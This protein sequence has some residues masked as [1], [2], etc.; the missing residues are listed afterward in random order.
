MEDKQLDFNQPFLSV[1]RTSITVSSGGRENVRKNNDE[2]VPKLPPLPA[3]K[4]ELKTDPVRDPG[5]VPFVW[6]QTP[7]RPKPQMHDPKRS[8]GSG[9]PK[10]PPVRALNLDKGSQASSTTRI[11]ASVGRNT[12]KEIK[13]EETGSCTSDE[14]D[15]SY[16]DA[17]GTLSRTESLFYNCN[18]S[19]ITGLD[20]PDLKP[21]WSF[22]TD[23]Q[24]RDFMMDRFLPAAKAVA[25]ETSLYSNRK[26]PV[27]R[28]QPRL[29]KEALF[30][31]RRCTTDQNMLISVPCYS[32]G[33]EVED[34]EDDDDDYDGP[35]NPSTGVCGL[36]PRLCLQSSF[37]LLNPVTG[38]RKPVQ[39][40]NSSVCKTKV[41]SSN[42]ASC[43]K[44]ENKNHT[45]P[46]YEPRST[47]RLQPTGLY[48]GKDEL[49]SVSNQI[50]H[51]RDLREVDGSHQCKS[52]QNKCASPFPMDFSQSA[53][54]EEKRLLGIAK[55]FKNSGVIRSCSPPNNVRNLQ[56]LFANEMNELES[57]CLSPVVEKILYVDS[58]HAVKP[59][60]SNSVSSDMK[61][62][63]SYKKVVADTLTKPSEIEEKDSR[64]SV[65]DFKYLEAVDGRTKVLS[66]SLESV[67]SGFFSLSDRHFHDGKM[68]KMDSYGPI[69]TLEQ[70]LL[71]S[72]SPKVDRSVKIDMKSQFDIDA[73]GNL[74]GLI[75]DS[76]LLTRDK[77]ADDGQLSTELSKQESQMHCLPPVPLPPPLPNSPSESWLMR[78]L[79]AISS[80]NFSSTS[81]LVMHASPKVQAFKKD[82]GG[83]K[84]EHI[85][86][87]SN[88]HG[89]SRFPEEV[90]API[91]EA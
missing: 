65:K 31:Q 17:A 69:K 54:T 45:N 58:V 51:I 32:Q 57:E 29:I 85:V 88:E 78:T 14:T 86:K 10:L 12:R 82:V 75:H 62:L 52:W 76:I 60:T 84:W 89:H 7:G 41:Q 11:P 49:K 71:K 53:T 81:S 22:S 47:D 67:A 36:F 6:E 4:S 50:R 25:S 59:Q 20:A 63:A 48:A 35:R 90:L 44:V 2:A 16:V 33:N 15:E 38:I 72:T 55:T 91:P 9:A 56:E 87:S 18:V 28:E 83:L 43:T 66:G 40:P 26:P 24:T 39:V 70:G 68:D 61:I 13:M 74:H 3:Y 37:C 73:A 42:A 34:S 23:Q 79:P 46:I 8:S 30:E 27:S 19:G 21:S 80:K 64:S 1:R 77:V 5:S